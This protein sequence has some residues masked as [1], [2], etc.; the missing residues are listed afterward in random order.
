[1][2]NAELTEALWQ[3]SSK[4]VVKFKHIDHYFIR[5]H[6]KGMD[7]IESRIDRF[8]TTAAKVLSWSVR[9]EVLAD[10]LKT[11]RKPKQ[12]RTILPSLSPEIVDGKTFA[13]REIQKPFVRRFCVG[14][15]RIN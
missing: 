8:C 11:T 14:C 15:T 5:S 12:D 4:F 13:I 10:N 7:L 3:L 1:M 9:H 2:I 6:G